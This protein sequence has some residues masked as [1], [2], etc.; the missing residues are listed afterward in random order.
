MCALTLAPLAPPPPATQLSLNCPWLLEKLPYQ[1]TAT[2]YVATKLFDEFDEIP[3][4]TYYVMVHALTQ[5]GT[6]CAWSSTEN[7]SAAAACTSPSVRATRACLWCL[8]LS[9]AAA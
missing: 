5:D 4:A 1:S 6:V 2:E 8:C 3:T 7:V 9:A